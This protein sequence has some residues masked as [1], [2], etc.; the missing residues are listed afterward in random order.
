MPEPTVIVIVEAPEPG[1]GMILGLKVI[2]TPLGAPVADRLIGLL[3]PLVSDVVMVDVPWFPGATLNELGEAEIPNVGGSVT[4]SVM[5][6]LCCIPP[7][8]PVMAIE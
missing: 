7:P 8:L 5:V 1:A 6:V 3:K 4:V 2:V